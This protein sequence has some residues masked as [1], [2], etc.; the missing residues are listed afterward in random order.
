MSTVCFLLESAD[1][2]HSADDTG[3]GGELAS[4]RGVRASS[5]RSVRLRSRCG[6]GCG[7]DRDRGRG[8]RRAA[9]RAA[10]GCGVARDAG[11]RAARALGPPLARAPGARVPPAGARGARAR[12]HRRPRGHTARA[13]PGALL[14]YSTDSLPLLYICIY[15][16]FVLGIFE[17]LYLST[18]LC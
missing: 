12:T 7:Q 17:Y 3:A 9:A 10:R 4:A 18:C 5:A 11:E 1:L 6:C 8:G 2:F 16:I 13:L 14:Y 15:S